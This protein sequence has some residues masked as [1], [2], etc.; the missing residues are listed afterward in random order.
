MVKLENNIATITVSEDDNIIMALKKLNEGSKRVLLVV[1][2][3]RK[4]KGTLTDGDIRRYILKTGTL[5]G[6][7]KN[8]YNRKPVTVSM[9]DINNKG[10]KFVKRIFKKHKIPILPVIDEEGNIQGYI[11]WSSIIDED[12]EEEKI[13]KLPEDVPVVIMAGGKGTRM[14]PFTS[15]LP[16]PLIPVGEKTAVEYIID[17]FRK[18][19]VKR[20]IL[21]LNY[22]GEIIETYFKTLQKDYEV[23]FIWE[24]EY[25]GT[26]GSLK[27]LE[28]RDDIPENF[29]VSNCDI[30][31]KANFKEIFDF[32]VKRS[33]VFTSVTSIQHYKIPY[34]VVETGEG[35]KILNIKEKPEYT[36]QI[37]TGVYIVNKKALKLIPFGYF[38]IPDLINVLL[39]NKYNVFAYPVKEK[40]YIDLGQWD[41]YRKAIKILSLI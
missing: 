31:V 29:I 26:C 21:T 2:G 10:R 27:F 8:V 35:G 1:N 36:F 37:N 20:F 14:R 33:S 41:E 6:K 28:D 5:E 32:H 18:F 23:D 22:K 12:I 24:P 38:D 17:E 7:V 9:D 25:L 3:D 4:L 11:E 13:E 30:V 16:K 34:G 19:G 39:K 15:V 40:D